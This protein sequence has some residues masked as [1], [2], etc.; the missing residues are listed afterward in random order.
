MN[1]ISC[2]KRESGA[3]FC[4]FWG[5]PSATVKGLKGIF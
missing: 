2:I 3:V 5:C 1:E 4:R